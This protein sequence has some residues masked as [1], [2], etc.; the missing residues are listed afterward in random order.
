M[1]AYSRSDTETMSMYSE[2]ADLTARITCTPETRDRVRA[3]KQ[4]TE[5]YEDVLQ[6]LIQVYDEN[7]DEST[8]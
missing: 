5:R 2:N 4:G 7:A 3:L 8:H 6:R 1:L